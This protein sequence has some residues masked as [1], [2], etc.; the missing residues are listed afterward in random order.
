MNALH[1]AVQSDITICMHCDAMDEIYVGWGT[2][3]I[4]RGE[5]LNYRD[6]YL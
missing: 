2:K 5:E 1:V 6:I 4:H 3:R